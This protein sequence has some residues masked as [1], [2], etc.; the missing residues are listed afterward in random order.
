MALCHT[1]IAVQTEGSNKLHYEA[2]SPEE[3]TLVS[4]SGKG[5]NL[6]CLSERSILIVPRRCKGCILKEKNSHCSDLLNL[7]EFNSS[8]KRMSVIT[9]DE[10]GRI[11]LLCN[12]VGKKLINNV[13][14]VV[15]NI[16]FDRLGDRGRT[17][18]QA[19]TKHLSSYA[20]DGLRTMVFAYPHIY[21]KTKATI[22][23]E[24]EEL[25]EKASKI[26]ENDLELLGVVVIEDRLQEGVNFVSYLSHTKL[27]FRVHKKASLGWTPGMAPHRR[28]KGDS[29]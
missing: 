15:C 4:N 3:V 9:R 28:Q 24:R 21:T 2:E 13:C 26:M 6:L 7:L 29:R 17:H 27:L 8:Q 19:T 10:S 23:P 14:V 22:G 11:F 1:G 25:M 18:Q 5:H 20:K 16:I 12:G